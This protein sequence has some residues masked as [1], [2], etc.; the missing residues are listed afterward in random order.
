MNDLRFDFIDPRHPLYAGELELRFRVLREPL[1]H[2]REDV[3][4]PFEDASLHLV[5]HA[6]GDVL[7]CVL[8]HPEDAH[9]GRLFQMAVSPS[10]QKKGL[11]AQLVRALEEE[12][13]TRGFRHVHLHARAPVVPFYER[14]GYAPYGELYEEVGIPHRNMQRDI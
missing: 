13:R 1:G 8:F 14:L 9:G 11:G 4:F 10:L 6:N 7:G 5:A 12:L 3:K 2:A